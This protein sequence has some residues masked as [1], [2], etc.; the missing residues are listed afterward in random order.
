[1]SHANETSVSALSANPR[2]RISRQRRLAFVSIIY[3]SFLLILVAI[4][5]G[6]RLRMDHV[7]SL[8]LFVVARQQKAQVADEKQSG[9]FEG[10]PLLLWRLK[11]NLDHAVW[12][13]TVLSTNSA[14]LRSQRP[15]EGM[16]PKQPGTIR[17]VCLGDSV[18][19]G[20][21]VPVVWPDK[22]TE[23]DPEWLPYPMLLE[24]QLRAANPNRK[25]EVITMA[26]P[27]Y[28]SHQGLAWL[29]R[30]ID[31]LQPDLLTVSFG[32]NDAS[33][34]DV[35]D[36]DAIKTNWSAVA[37]RWLM[38]HSQAFAHATSW[39][40]TREAKKELAARQTQPQAKPMVAYPSPR[41]SQPEYLE[42][43]LAIERLGQQHGSAVIVIAAPYRDYSREAPEADLMLQYRGAL[44]STMQQ[45]GIPFLE[46][47]ELT[48]EAFPSN[49][50][51]FG[52]RI[53]PNHMG[54]RLMASELLK[55]IGTKHLLADLS[56][57]E[58]AP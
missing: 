47:R 37:V 53:H 50:G 9:I 48:E 39:L 35:P 24:K 14:H 16:E 31:Q 26:V 34:S 49:E 28:T 18:T 23:Y 12:D 25:I 44:K 32:W 43:M 54:H 8:D 57:P 56:I 58:L 20:F 19:F 29:R 7:S 11:P 15:S 30:D 21:R 5:A 4:E 3:V 27:G 6:T 1:M 22:P 42:N 52:E 45:R 36:R 33:L 51:W 13:F 10:D 17:I 41:V 38:D 46:V 55:L 40:R 2:S